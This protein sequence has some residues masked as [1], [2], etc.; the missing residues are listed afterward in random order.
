VISRTVP[1]IFVT[2]CTGYVGG[3][4]APALL[5]EGYHIR[6]LAREPRKLEDRPWRNNPLV[7]VVQGD[8]S[9]INALT[10]ALRGC[11]A[12]FYLMHS[13]QTSGG[14]YA[15]QDRQLAK[16]FADAAAKAKVSR[17]IYLGGLGEMGEGLSAHL[18]SR[19]EVEEIL[20]STGIPVTTFR[21]AMII[22]SGSASFEI[23]RYLVERLPV[24]VTPQWVT[25]ES[26]PVSIVDV[27]YWLV[28]C[29]EVPET[30]GQT[31]EI[32]GADVLPYRELMQIMAQELGLAKR[33]IIPLP[34]LSP[35]L[36]SLWIG[37]V[38][39]VSYRIARP[40]A[41]GLRNRVVVVKNDVQ[42]LMPHEAQG[43]RE[44]IRDAVKS[45]NS[46]NVETR[47]SAA[48]PIPGDPQ[49]AGGTVFTDQ[50][51]VVIN[52]DAKSV[53]AAVCRIG[54]GNGWY[55][56]DVLWQIR[57][58]M[59]T[60]VGGPGLRRGRRNSE[61]VE[62]GEAI[63]FWRVVDIEHDRTLSLLA[64]MKLPGEA[65]LRFDIK[66]EPGDKSTKLT[67]TA[68][69][70]PKGLLGIAY[71]YS[72]LPLHNLVFGGMLN[73]IRRTAEREAYAASR[74]EQ[75]VGSR[76]LAGYGR[77]RL[78]LG[79]SAVGTI[80]TLSTIAL[81]AGIPKLVNSLV[82]GSAPLSLG[83][84][85]VFVLIYVGLQLPFD[86]LG[87]YLLPRWFARSHQSFGK[88]SI[89][90]ARG[91]MVH[92]ALL[93]FIAG[94]MMGVGRF[95]GVVAVVATG[96]IAGLALL[97]SRFAVASSLASLRVV[98]ATTTNRLAGGRPESTL[99]SSYDEGF[100]G[101]ITGL[102]RPTNMFFPKLWTEVLKPDAFRLEERRRALAVISGSW[103][104]GRIAAITFT[105]GGLAFAGLM[106][107]D[108]MLG[109]PGGT[110]GFSLW[111]TLWSFFGLLT[112]PTLSRW[113]VMEID[114]M[115]GTEGYPL[116]AIRETAMTLDKLQDGEPVRANMVE[117]I[118][119]PIPSVDS[120]LNGPRKHGRIG[121]W[122]AARTAVYLSVSGLGLL[123]RAVHCNCGRP[124]LWA[125]LPTD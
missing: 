81:W 6:C 93:F 92:S 48:G 22:G 80:V 29:L 39:P 66:A 61:K 46:N 72:V 120:R 8:L 10:D 91:I 86:L 89:A 13:M 94:V 116:E 60:L 47:W 1:P 16:R 53:F 62:F 122:D 2:G 97:K 17:I 112:L 76:G 50:R 115:V 18:K 124:S 64:E 113:G 54:G 71:W 35:R 42:K 14:E 56:G 38:T 30:I 55:A 90:L 100:T 78:C 79:I 52:S 45:V 33:L 34:V 83:A 69:F 114:E 85:L 25:T 36:S 41:E 104:R 43:V 59:D 111:F 96:T 20:A 24:M 109:T 82:E 123:G 73:G 5:S 7:E 12:A 102:V 106:V 49:W 40:L 118:F 67:M 11:G 4:L 58:W 121:F 31:L 70:R 84:L 88:F 3:R 99:V 23:L 51:S 117:T 75:P 28:H 105:I 26:Q 95:G 9:D 110:I 107:G 125:F 77:A 74:N 63:D 119:H 98:P 101:S 68:R 57:G 65:M 27:I 19:R 21:A 108:P 15:E 32:G 37:V 87:G 44:S 103:L